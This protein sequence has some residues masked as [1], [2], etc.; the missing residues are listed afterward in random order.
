MS[1]VVV[2]SP[3]LVPPVYTPS[4]RHDDGK[5]STPCNDDDNNDSKERWIMKQHEYNLAML[6]NR[7]RDMHSWN[8]G[9]FDQKEN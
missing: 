3:S 1:V 8:L 9:N 5:S 4:Q 6:E 2:P 7:R